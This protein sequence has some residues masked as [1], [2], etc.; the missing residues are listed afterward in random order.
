MN[1]FGEGERN[2]RLNDRRVDS[3]RRITFC[4][5]KNPERREKIRRSVFDRRNLH[6]LQFD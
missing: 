3:E 2:W 6:K 1:E 5:L 4:V